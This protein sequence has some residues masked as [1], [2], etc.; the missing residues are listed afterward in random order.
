MTGLSYK[1]GSS[2][3][4]Q[5]TNVDWK[6]LFML[7]KQQMVLAPRRLLAQGLE[8]KLMEEEPTTPISVLTIADID[9][10][11]ELMKRNGNTLGFLPRPALE[12]Y[13]AKEGVLGA[14][15]QDGQ[16]VGYLMYAGNR[17]RFRIAQLC[18]TDSRRGEGVARD[19]LEVLKESAST[20]K[21]ITLRC[22]NDF[23]AHRL[24]PKL[25]FVPISESTGRSKEGH[26]LTFWR[27]QLARHDQLELFRANMS[28]DVLD[29]VIDAQVFFDFDRP[30]SNLT[31]PSK[32]LISDL[33][34]DSVN[35]WFTD[36][37]LSE[38]NRSSSAAKREEARTRA[39][40]FLEAK[41]HP[42]LVDS[43]RAKLK[44]ILPSRTPNQL[45]DIMH[46]AKTAASEIDLF[47]TRDQLL[48]DR[49]AQIGVAASVQVLSPTALILKLQEL[50]GDHP[51]AP[52]HV[53]GPGLSWRRLTSEELLG[54][55]FDRFLQ[56]RERPGDLRTR[57]HSFLSDTPRT[58]VEALWSSKEPVAIRGMA[59]S[60]P[61][62]L[63]VLLCR[64]ASSVRSSSMRLFPIADVI[65]RAVT[66]GIDVVKVDNSAVPLDLLPATL[67]MGFTRWDGG[68]VRFCFTRYLEQDGVLST[69]AG[70]LPGCGDNYGDMSSLEL[71]RSCS[72]LITDAA[73][74]YFLIPIRPN[75][76]RSLIDRHLSSSDMFG[77]DPDVLLRWSNVY[78]RTASQHR[79]LTAP[80]RILWYVS[81]NSREIVATSHLDQVVLDRPKELFRRFRRY[82]AFEWR[83]LYKTCD[84][85]VSK[86]VMALLFSHTFPFRRRVP[87]NEIWEVFDEDGVARS[88]QSPRSIH[89]GTFQK[90]L[91]LGYSEQS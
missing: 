39:R 4:D 25:G 80:G 24:W 32:V 59:Y 42:S 57:V 73:Q 18:V 34:L 2:T 12:E 3:F 54:F 52:E 23:P 16:L 64:V 45:S 71:E 9:S 21:V 37:L 33:F 31:Q 50:S 66:R 82:G 36:E 55:P 90:L 35:L 77:G 81:G 46:L 49:A 56:H 43:F 68:F 29:A 14:K 87:L 85:D 13:L 79:M 47:V 10:V 6:G 76:A 17:D 86:K 72:P 20:Q 89:L 61:S 15:N 74:S 78:Y 75:F 53:S 70:L 1:D 11:D 28:D 84:G 60:S 5:N 22:R 38:I 67:E 58:E 65:N 27:Y 48:L 91:E 88:L 8:D 19:L 69:I 7:G 40:Q 41:H 30:D 62:V 83:H 26:L 63:T 44:Q 51:Y